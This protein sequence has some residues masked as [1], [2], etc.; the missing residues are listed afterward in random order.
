MSKVLSLAFFRNEHSGYETAAAGAGRGVFFVGF[1]GAVL[2]AWKH[3]MPGWELWIHHD[4]RATEFPYWKV[5]EGL[6]EA[7]ENVQLHY[8]GP[9]AFLCRSMLW[10]M[11]PAFAQDVDVFA[12]RDVDSL[13]MPRDFKMLEEFAASYRTAHAILDSESHSGPFMGGM[14]AFNAAKLRKAV[15]EDLGSVGELLA[16]F[17]LNDPNRH[18]ADQVWLNTYL[19]P[20]LSS[21]TF[22]H[23]KRE[24]ILYPMAAAIK[25]VAPQA[26]EE[27]KLANHVGGAFEAEKVCRWY[28]QHHPWPLLQ[29]IEREVL[30]C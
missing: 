8:M 2:R 6:N 16:R 30:G 24:D 7:D 22:I 13:P 1:L 5:I 27:D 28:D 11:D 29:Q 18:G 17:P 26:C 10:R 25:R 23:Q 21:E 9:S 12:C 20:R 14:V 19:W 3:S 15:G 4:R